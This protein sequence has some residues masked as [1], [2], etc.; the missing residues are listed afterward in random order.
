MC[1]LKTFVVRLSSGQ[2]DGK[3]SFYFTHLKRTLS[4]VL[5]QEV[6]KCEL[7]FVSWLGPT[8]VECATDCEAAP[9]SRVQ[10]ICLVEKEES[11][12]PP[13]PREDYPT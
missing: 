6:F 13:P 3:L 10:L 7:E 8:W 2:T 4:L 9:S 11:P 12:P 5:T 1:I